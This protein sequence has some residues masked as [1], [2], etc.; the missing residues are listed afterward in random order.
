MMAPS[1]QCGSIVGPVVSL[2]RRAQ[3][4][5]ELVALGLTNREIAQRLFL[6]ERTAEWHIEQI[7]N[8]LGFTSRSQVAAWVSRSQVEPAVP[9]AGRRPRG[10]LPAQLTTFVGRDRELSSV[11]NLVAAHRLVT[12]T[13]PGGTGKTRLVLRLAEELQADIPQGILLC[14]LAPVADASLVGDAIARALGDNRTAPD[15]LGVARDLLRERSVLLVLDNCVIRRA[16]GS[17]GG[18]PCGP[19]RVRTWT[20]VLIQAARGGS[21]ADTRNGGHARGERGLKHSPGKR[22]V[23]PPVSPRT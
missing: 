11:F 20:Q 19:F 17:K 4:V 8:K 22:P 14:D 10:N 3:E 2:T 15:R 16:A 5:A 12:V 18:R 23:F 1:N 21:G 9:V 13:G 7:F 6:S